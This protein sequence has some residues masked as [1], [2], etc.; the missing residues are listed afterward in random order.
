MSTTKR[1]FF[2]ALGLN[3][4]DHWDCHLYQMM[5]EQVEKVKE[6]LLGDPSN[7]RPTSQ[8]KPEPWSYGDFTE[9]AIEVALWRIT[10]NANEVTRHL[11][12]IGDANERGD[13]NW[14]ARWI[15][16]HLFRNR[17]ARNLR[18]KARGSSIEAEKTG[19]EGDGGSTQ[20]MQGYLPSSSEPGQFYDY[21]RDQ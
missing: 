1:Q 5:N 6:K 14:P 19:D 13:Q 9:A 8:N 7:R 15:L 20:N 16:Y 12:Q 21:I 2:E 4:D 18:R 10:E 11:F 3:V 17:D